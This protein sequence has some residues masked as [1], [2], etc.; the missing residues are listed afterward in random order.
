VALGPVGAEPAAQLLD[1]A[2]GDVR[3]EDLAMAGAALS[4][5]IGAA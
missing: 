2:L 4:K 5:I 3:D 1:A